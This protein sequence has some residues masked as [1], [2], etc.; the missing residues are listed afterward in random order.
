MSVL[1]CAVQGPAQGC[2][3]VE[4]G[5]R[6]GSGP[7]SMA[8]TAAS[9]LPRSMGA[10]MWPGGCWQAG[11]GCGFLQSLELLPALISE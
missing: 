11:G 1:C 10:A 9:M 5:D 4:G 8:P 2:L 6:P 7:L 3:G